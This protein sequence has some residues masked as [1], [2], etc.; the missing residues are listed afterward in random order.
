MVRRLSIALALCLTTA[1]C[2]ASDEDLNEDFDSTES[3]LT[4]CSDETILCEDDESPP[5]SKH[6]TLMAWNGSTG[7]ITFSVNGSVQTAKIATSTKVKRA[8][9]NRFH[10]GDPI[11]PLI[12][13]WNTLFMRPGQKNFG[14]LN[15]PTDSSAGTFSG[16]TQSLASANARMRIKLNNGNNTVKSLRPVP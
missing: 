13:Q 3:A 10:P 1:G 16:L 9:I 8:P 2:V 14:T 7:V 11:R 5:P 4:A 6:A 15:P 12:A